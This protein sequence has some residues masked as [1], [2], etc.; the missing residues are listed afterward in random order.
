MI[1]GRKAER[2]PELGGASCGDNADG[3]ASDGA[4]DHLRGIREQCPRDGRVATGDHEDGDHDQRERNDTVVCV[5]RASGCP[6]HLKPGTNEL[7]LSRLAMVGQCAL[8]AERSQ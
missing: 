3:E 8:S 6:T 4:G 1:I 7:P 5:R 2:L